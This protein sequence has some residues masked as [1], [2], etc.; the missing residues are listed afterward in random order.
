MPLFP[1]YNTNYNKCK[2]EIVLLYIIFSINR[3][4]EL[5]KLGLAVFYYLSLT[6]II[7]IENKKINV[8]I[9]QCNWI[10]V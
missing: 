6:P 9:I 1:F 3:D 10:I 8:C 4:C 7:L 5:K 2:M